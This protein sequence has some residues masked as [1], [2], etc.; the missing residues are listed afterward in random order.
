MTTP[1]EN[2]LYEASDGL[3]FLTLNR[4]ESRNAQN[5]ALLYDLDDALVAAA[6]D[7]QIRVII[8]QGAG[9]SFSSGH[10]IKS[11]S[12]PDPRPQIS[13]WPKADGRSGIEARLYRE[14][15]M[16]LG[17]LRRW[18]DLP[19]PTIASVHGYCI[20]AGLM[21]AWVC[22][23][24][25]A[26]ED[27]LFAD[28]VLPMGIPGGEYF[29]YPY[30]MPPRV[31]KEFMFLGEPMN[32]NRALEVGMINRVVPQGQLA[33]ETR[34]IA[35]RI[36]ESPRLAITLAKQIVNFAEDAMGQRETMEYAFGLHQLAHA[37]AREQTGEEFFF[38]T[39]AE[40]KTRLL[41]DAAGNE[42]PDDDAHGRGSE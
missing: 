33:D 8:I 39:P 17:L 7:D 15:E 20:G 40:V 19:K 16:F 27:A 41:G 30:Q 14:Q 23:L 34:R 1:S 28:P 21:L 29:A 37:N 6:Q 22:D 26:S 31:A 3:A 36:S 11:H 9:T 42:E 18:R 10:D 2:V 12:T 4:P 35:M 25:V 32:A 5:T 13:M 24:I 38:T